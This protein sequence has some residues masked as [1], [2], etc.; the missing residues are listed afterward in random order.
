MPGEARYREVLVGSGSGPRGEAGDDDLAVGLE[1]Q[2][3]GE[4]VA[5]EEVHRGPAVEAEGGIRNAVRI[6]PREGEV[7]SA[8]APRVPGDQEAPIGLGEDARGRILVPGEIERHL[9]SVAEAPIED[10]ARQETNE[11]EI[12]TAGSVRDSGRDDLAVLP[13]RHRARLVGTVA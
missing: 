4:V 9:A 5:A 11:R 8:A 13:D 3:G 10:A 1:R 2:A 12:A 7:E 6:E